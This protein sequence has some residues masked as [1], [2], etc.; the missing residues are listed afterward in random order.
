ML[1]AAAP[2]LLYYA[3]WL[4]SSAL[5]L[6]DLLLA[7]LNRL[8]RHIGCACDFVRQFSG[9]DWHLDEPPFAPNSQLQF[10][11]DFLF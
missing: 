7:R 3:L 8:R 6:V 2:V 11:A 4:L 1:S 9:L 10:L 5:A